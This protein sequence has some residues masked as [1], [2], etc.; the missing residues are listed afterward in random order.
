M[1]RE[2]GA[3]GAGGATTLEEDEAAWG[4]LVGWE[5]LRWPV[6]GHA[7]V[8]GLSPLVVVLRTLVRVALT[9]VHVKRPW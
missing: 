8:V 2:A 1:A 3:T 9:Y 4:D 7:G 5:D 6:A